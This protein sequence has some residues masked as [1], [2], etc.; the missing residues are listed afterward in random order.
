MRTNK[1]KNN[2]IQNSEQTQPDQQTQKHMKTNK[3]NKNYTSFLLY[4]HA[5]YNILGRFMGTELKWIVGMLLNGQ[6]IF[7]QVTTNTVPYLRRYRQILVNNEN[8]QRIKQLEPTLRFY[9]EEYSQLNSSMWHANSSVR[10]ILG[11]K[12]LVEWVIAAFWHP[13]LFS[14]DPSQERRTKHE[15]HSFWD[16]AIGHHGVLFRQSQ[17]VKL[18]CTVPTGP[19]DSKLRRAA[20]FNLKVLRHCGS[21]APMIWSLK[22]HN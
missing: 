16:V 18:Y 7:V 17:G 2:N 10:S 9:Q 6:I 4:W 19:T 11:N 12:G 13:H 1:K 21:P 3:N 15:K 14:L 22:L 20:E 5:R 8:S